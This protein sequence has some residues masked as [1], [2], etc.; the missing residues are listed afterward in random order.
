MLVNVHTKK[1]SDTVTGL[2]CFHI[3]FDWP[4]PKSKL[5]AETVVQK[6]IL[7]YIKKPSK[8]GCSS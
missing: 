2:L 6:Y 3:A 7:M 4:W 5:I 8:E 1:S